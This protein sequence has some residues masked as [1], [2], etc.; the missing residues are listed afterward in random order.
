[1][2]YF[3]S[4]NAKS[5]FFSKHQ[6]AFNWLSV[7]EKEVLFLLVP[8]HQTKERRDGDRDLKKHDSSG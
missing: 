6:N 4:T 7:M 8:F 2:F 1:M 3:S 5:I